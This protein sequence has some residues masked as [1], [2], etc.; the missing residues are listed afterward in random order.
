MRRARWALVLALLVVPAGL[1][2]QG[3]AS[4]EAL[5]DRAARAWTRH[6]AGALG[7]LLAS[8]GITLRLEGQG[9]S[10]VSARQAQASLAS[11]LSR[12][13]PGEARVRRAA[14]LG[15]DPPRGLVELEWITAPRGTREPVRYVIFLGLTRV[16]DRWRVVE[17]RVLS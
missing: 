1:Q 13:E 5:G 17:I 2:A 3:A 4:P 11:F 12:H 16:G 6:D 15:G 8:D 14:A 9:H 10:G 7:A